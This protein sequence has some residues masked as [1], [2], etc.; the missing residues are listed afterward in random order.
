MMPHNEVGSREDLA[1]YKIEMA[2]H[3]L[4]SAVALRDIQ[5]YRGANNRAYYAIYNAISAVHALEGKAYKKH[6]DALSNFNKNYVNEGKFPK[7]YGRQIS[8]AEVI[9]HASDYDDFYIATKEDVLQMVETATEL[10]ELIEE[11][12]SQKTE[13]LYISQ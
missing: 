6:K 7:K 3:T 1:K 13:S 10:I 12:C 5:D 8:T 4:K 11:Y 9:R 2:K